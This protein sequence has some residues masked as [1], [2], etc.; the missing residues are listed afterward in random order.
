MVLTLPAVHAI[1]DRFPSARITFLT[2]KENAPLLRGFRDVNEV[3]MVDRAALRSGN[4]FK[5]AGEFWGLL[6][7]LRAGTF[8]LV[9]DFQGYGE[10]AWLTRITGALQRWG[11]VHRSG[12]GWAYTQ[13][14]KRITAVHPAEAHLGLLKRCGLSVGTVRNEFILPEA[15]VND[16]RAWFANHQLD[17]T[18]PT[19]YLQPL[20]SGAHK[21]WP[22]ENYLAVARHW[23]SRGVQII[24][25]GGPPDRVVLAPVRREDFALSAG[26]PL[27]VT[28]GIMQLSTLV[29]GGDTGALHLAVAQ[30]KRVLMLLPQNTPGS[31]VPFQHPDWVVVAPM[32][33]AIAKIP[34][35]DVLAATERAFNELAGSASC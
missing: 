9:V 7:R 34:V 8:S 29:T 24:F 21:N 5:M 16:A 28:G 35:A 15:A 27:L 12:R 22:L 26:V 25:G 2:S 23:R 6:R 32:P 4:P 14:I 3:I 20:T 31:P 18:R 1:R 11:Q 30:G 19:L 13:Q 10:T 33:V 17:P